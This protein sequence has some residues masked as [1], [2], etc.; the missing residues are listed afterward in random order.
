MRTKDADKWIKR[1]EAQPSDRL[2]G[3]IDDLLASLPTA[4][5]ARTRTRTVRNQTIQ[6]ALAAVVLLLAVVA[7]PL[8]NGDNSNVWAQALENARNIGDYAFHFTRVDKSLDPKHPETVAQETSV[9]HI[10]QEYGSYTEDYVGGELVQ[11][12]YCI[13]DSNELVRVLPRTKQYVRSPLTHSYRS[14]NPKEWVLGLLTG[15]YSELGEK[16]VDG[17]VLVGIENRRL[18]HCESDRYMMHTKIWFDRTTMLPASIER[19]FTSNTQDLR[20]VTRYDQYRYDLELA[21]ELFEP[22]IPGDYVPTIVG[23]LK[24]FSELTGGEY[25]WSIHH[26]A[27]AGELRHKVGDQAQV[28][29]AIEANTLA[30]GIYGYEAF[31][32]ADAFYERLTVESHDFGYL[33]N[34]V[35]SGDPNRVVLYWKWTGPEQDYQVVWGDLRLETFTRAQL[36]E[37]ARAVGDAAVLLDFLEKD[38]GADVLLLADYLGQIGDASAVPALL[39]HADGTGAPSARQAFR[40]AIETIRRHQEQLDPSRALIAGRATYHNGRRVTHA[41]IDIE[42]QLQI[43]D[44]EGYFVMAVPCGDPHRYR[45][46]R[47]YDSSRKQSNL[48]FWR[49]ID[50]RD[51]LTVVPD[52]PA[53]VRGRVVDREGK[54][55]HDV[56]VELWARRGEQVWPLKIRTKT[57]ADGRF[58]LDDVPCGAALQLL[59]GCPEKAD[60]AVRM[61]I[62]A[63][64]PDQQ[65]DLGDLVLPR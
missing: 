33:G 40:V 10:S 8:F 24:L 41:S 23:A 7:L 20:H 14:G 63:L 17:R 38:D 36:I 44:R 53:A 9:C 29:K 28:E 2:D 54:P 52:W 4:G 59:L 58:A 42:G 47:V 55:R 48:F 1:L 60:N 49:K 15:E 26:G 30:G 65:T 6:L 22:D 50:Q 21:P 18:R 11:K 32:Q 62:G 19:S 57:D 61:P 12:S 51:R 5:P 64:T 34:R 31:H 35:T 39:R 46:G 37:R 16:T 45:L 3:R 27:M 25:P 56:N 43:A 13:V